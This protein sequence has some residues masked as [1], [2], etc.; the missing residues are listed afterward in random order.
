M[1]RLHGLNYLHKGFIF[2]IV[3][4]LII[5]LVE[6]EM[7]K[8]LNAGTVMTG[9]LLFFILQLCE[10][11]RQGFYLDRNRERGLHWR[12]GV[13]QF[14]KWPYLIMAFFDVVLHRRFQYVTSQK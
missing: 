10:R 6:G 11:F 7:P 14:A 12:A 2:P 5:V 1:N 13:L 8:G 4:L 3:F 9:G